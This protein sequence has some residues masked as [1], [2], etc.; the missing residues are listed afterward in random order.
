[1]DLINAIEKGDLD[2]QS[3]INAARQ[4]YNQ[5]TPQQQ[6]LLESTLVERLDRLEVELEQY[7]QEVSR[8]TFINWLLI[9]HLTSATIFSIIYI[10]KYHKRWFKKNG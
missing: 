6:A 3:K 10:R 5:L 1:M 9:I 7:I 8:Q 4:A 2:N